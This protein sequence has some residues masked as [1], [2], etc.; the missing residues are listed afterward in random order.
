[1]CKIESSDCFWINVALNQ[2]IDPIKVPVSSE[3]K[4]PSWTQVQRKIGNIESNEKTLDTNEN[5]ENAHV[6]LDFFDSEYWPLKGLH[7][8]SL[9][10]SV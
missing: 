6:Q 7:C 2:K 1:M 10:F 5:W 3:I 9:D 8:N 4:G